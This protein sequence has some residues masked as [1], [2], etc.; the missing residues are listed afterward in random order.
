MVKSRCSAELA[1]NARPHPYPHYGTDSGELQGTAADASDGK[2]L[3][4]CCYANHSGP[5][6]MLK[7]RRRRTI[8]P[9]HRACRRGWSGLARAAGDPWRRS[10]LVGGVAPQALTPIRKGPTPRA[11]CSASSS[12]IRI[13]RRQRVRSTRKQAPIQGWRRRAAHSRRPACSQY[14]LMQVSD[15]PAN[16]ADTVRIRLSPQSAVAGEG[17]KQE[18][19]FRERADGRAGTAQ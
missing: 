14:Q 11:R 5:W 3:I 13:R 18:S 1:P 19:G 10:C 6:R 16:R 7:V 2:P 12:S 15:R 8:L 4:S 9:P 17:A